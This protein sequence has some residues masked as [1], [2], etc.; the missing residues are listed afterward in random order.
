MK[1]NFSIFAL[2]LTT[3]LSA[4]FLEPTYR[5]GD[6]DANFAYW[7]GFDVGYT[8]AE[9]PYA[10]L[11]EFEVN[12]PFRGG[13]LNA[14]MGQYGAPG[15]FITSSNGIYSFGEP[16]A[17]KVY[18]NPLYDPGEILFQTMT[19]SGSQSLPDFSSIKLF[20]RSDENGAWEEAAFPV[21]A[22]IESSDSNGNIF[23]AWEWDV[24]GITIAD[25]YI[26]FSYELI[27]SS[28]IEAQLDTNETFQQQLSG[29]GVSVDT[30]VPF[31]LLFGTINRTPEKLIYNDGE[32]VTIEVSPSPSFVFVKWVGPFGEST[33]NPLVLSVTDN[34]EIRAILATK[35][36]GVW[37][38]VSFESNHGGGISAS[39]WAASNDYDKDGL[40]NAMEYAIG[41]NPESGIQEKRFS[42]ALVE[43]DGVL[44]PTLTFSQQIAAE[45]LVY[46]V[47]V[48]TDLE[49]W[50]SNSDPGGPYVSEPEVLHTNDDGTQQVVVRSLTPFDANNPQFMNLKISLN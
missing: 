7:D 44:Y 31:G 6:D 30:N 36:Y 48:S 14:R 33:D 38:Q 25:Y 41:S 28:I 50:H 13:N 27:H 4:Q 17:F 3:S 1:L 2:C 21:T 39:D 5:L 47:C 26:Q 18:D 49:S 9:P 37:R 24:S 15:A 29:F 32:T 42:Q 12:H 40:I 16:T 46:D 34:L 8:D 10:G 23:T 11:G 43:I 35:E 45:D 19:L 20:Y 22:A